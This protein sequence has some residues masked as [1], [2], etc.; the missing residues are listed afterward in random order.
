MTAAGPE[1]PATTAPAQAE[2]LCGDGADARYCPVFWSQHAELGDLRASVSDYRDALSAMQRER[3]EARE[4]LADHK[5]L[6]A[7]A[8]EQAG[9]LKA[10]AGE[11]LGTFN[12]SGDGHRAR[13]GQVQIAKWRTRAGIAR[14]G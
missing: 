11:I 9:S 6:L 5:A 3:D 8:E 2:A 10:L 7:D 13:A 1:T 12:A 14:E 4:Q